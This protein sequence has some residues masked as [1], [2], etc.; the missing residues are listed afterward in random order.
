MKISALLA[1][2]NFCRFFEKETDSC[3]SIKKEST[4]GLLQKATPWG[5]TSQNHASCGQ[6][7]MRQQ[8]RHVAHSD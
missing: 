5:L 1:T 4:V 8:A 3:I 7:R 6:H 2:T